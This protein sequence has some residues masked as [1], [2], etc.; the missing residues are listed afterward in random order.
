MTYDLVVVDPPWAWSS[1]SI[2]GAGRAPKYRTIEDMARVNLPA[3]LAKDAVVIL[4]VID[5]MLP[6]AMELVKAWN[7]KFVT[8]GLY[9]TKHK[10]SGKEHLGT[11]YYTRANPEQAWILRQGKGLRVIGKGRVRRW[12]HAP[13]GKHSEK[14]DEAYAR[15]E[16]LFGDVRRADVFARKRRPGWDAIGNEIDGKDINDAI[17]AISSSHT[18]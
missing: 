3:I 7:L 8:V 5:S 17:A 11:G 4:W 2:K 15:L 16:E 13:V 18:L 1:W 12:L 14:P 10:P 6:Q 9:W